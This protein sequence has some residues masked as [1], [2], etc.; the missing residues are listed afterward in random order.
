MSSV[1]AETLARLADG[2][3][4][5][6]AAAEQVMDAVMAGE[7]SPAQIG[8]ILMALRLRGESAEEISGFAR[9]MRNHALSVLIPRRPVVDTCGTGGDGSHSF[10]ISTAAALVAA[11]AGATVIKHGNRGASSKSGSAD[12]LE[13]LGIQLNPTRQTWTQMVEETGFGFVFAQ[14][15]HTAMRHAGPVRK[16]L[17]IRTVFNL[18]GPLTNPASPEYQVIGVFD[19][20]RIALMAEALV[21]L[22]VDRALVVHG[23][24]LDEVTLSGVTDYALV[25][26]GAIVHGQ[27]TPDS[28]GLPWYPKAAIR[29]GE[30]AFNADICLG[31]LANETS[32]YSDVVLANASVALL[33][34]R[35]VA[36]L[37]EGVRLARD[38]ITSGRAAKILQQLQ[39]MS[40][41]THSGS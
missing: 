2:E 7:A 29:G 32:A 10:N 19:A 38:A 25:D 26:G 3:H 27:W 23:D 8:A 21:H 16:E 41:I 30:P 39:E 24:G 31:I 14:S 6:A 1:I 11:G 17:G 40:E 35:M 4:L 34:A 13:A 20:D 36:D 5:S 22:Q 18:L 9:S 15:V 12:L 37:K 33:A 28:F